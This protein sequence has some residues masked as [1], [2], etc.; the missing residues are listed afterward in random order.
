MHDMLA[1]IEAKQDEMQGLT[2][3][4]AANVSAVTI[5]VTTSHN[6]AQQ[7]QNTT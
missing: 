3:K 2:E 5:T 6:T 1:G 4:A 7:G